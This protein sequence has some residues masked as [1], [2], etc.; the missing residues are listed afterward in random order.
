[1]RKEG[2]WYRRE[3]VKYF[4]LRSSRLLDKKI[5]FLSLDLK[6]LIIKEEKG[7]RGDKG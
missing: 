2:S 5:L 6:N 4:R 3:E 1:M 7:G